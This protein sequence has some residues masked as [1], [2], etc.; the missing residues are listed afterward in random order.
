MRGRVPQIIAAKVVVVALVVAAL[1]GVLAV[2]PVLDV[3]VNVGVVLETVTAVV[4]L[5]VLLTVIQFVLQPA[6][7]LVQLIATQH[8]QKSHI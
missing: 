5:L 6:S 1:H 3:L 8:R 4:L 2:E 7:I